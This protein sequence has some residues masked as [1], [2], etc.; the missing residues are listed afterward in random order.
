ML[1][2]KC[3]LRSVVRGMWSEG[4]LLQGG[5]WEERL[6][7]R[8][9]APGLFRSQRRGE[10]CTLAPF[11]SSPSRE[12]GRCLQDAHH[13]QLRRPLGQTTPG[14]GQYYQFQR[15]HT[16]EQEERDGRGEGGQTEIP[17]VGGQLDAQVGGLPCPTPSC[18]PAGGRREV[19][20]RL[21]E[22]GGW[23][24]LVIFIFI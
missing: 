21:E 9:R 18:K 20:T 22:P 2:R 23:R 4:V 1:E 17:E 15:A 13:W 6:Y 3:L 5:K 24:L 12:G 8:R 19:K 7:Q 10:I 16:D 11:S 14:E